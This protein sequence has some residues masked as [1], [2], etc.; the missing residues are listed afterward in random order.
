[1]NGTS[2]NKTLALYAVLAAIVSLG[3][4]LFAFVAADAHVTDVVVGAVVGFWLRES[5]YIGKAVVTNPSS[6][7]AP[8]PPPAPAPAA[9]PSAAGA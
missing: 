8:D 5:T 6:A 3:L 1:V 9:S 4:L 7:P 2:T